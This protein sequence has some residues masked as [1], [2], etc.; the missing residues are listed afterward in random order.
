ME[1]IYGVFKSWSFKNE[2][3]EFVRV[4]IKKLGYF[5]FLTNFDTSFNRSTYWTTQNASFREGSESYILNEDGT[6]YANLASQTI[7]PI[8]SNQLY[9]VVIKL[10]LKENDTIRFRLK[11]GSWQNISG[12]SGAYKDG[13]F[14][15]GYNMG[16][17]VSGFPSFELINTDG[18]GNDS[19]VVVYDATI[20]LPPSINDP[21]A[22]G[23]IPATSR[24]DFTGEGVEITWNGQGA[25]R[26]R[27][28][29]A[30][31]LK[32]HLNITN[33]LDENFI[34]DLLDGTSQK[35]I[36]EVAKDPVQYYVSTIWKGYMQPSF[37]VIENTSFPYRVT[38]TANDSYG[39]FK[40]KQFIEFDSPDQKKINYRLSNIL[41]SYPNAM[42]LGNVNLV[43]N[44][45]FDQ[46]KS[47]WYTSEA[48]TVTLGRLYID[49]ATNPGARSPMSM[50]GS[51]LIP[52]K[53]YN[54]AFNTRT[55]SG[56]L[57]VKDGGGNSTQIASVNTTNNPNN[58]YKNFDF[59]W[60]QKDN[61]GLNGEPNG[62]HF[63]TTDWVGDIGQ[64][65]CSTAEDT[66]FGKYVR[67]MNVNMEWEVPAM[68]AGYATAD[69]FYIC[70]GAFAS[71]T[72]FP[73]EYKEQDAFN[74]ALKI[75]NLLGF[76]WK[77]QLWFTQPNNLER[78]PAAVS[79]Y[80]YDHTSD[81]SSSQN[82]SDYDLTVTI[83]QQ[84]HVLLAG[85]SFTYEPS[86]N[87]VLATYT[88]VSDAFNISGGQDI[89]EK[90]WVS[91]RPINDFY[92]YGGQITADTEYTLKW[93]NTYE[94]EFY[95]SDISKGNGWT[96]A[97]GIF[98]FQSQVVIKAVSGTKTEWLRM[99]PDGELE[100]QSQY[101]NSGFVLTRG[102]GRNVT[103]AIYDKDFNE[104]TVTGAL[105]NSSWRDPKEGD[106]ITL[107][108]EDIATRFYTP[109]P[110]P[111]MYSSSSLKFK[112]KIPAV[113]ETMSLFIKVIPLVRYYEWRAGGGGG[114][115]EIF[116]SSYI[117]RIAKAQSITLE[118]EQTNSLVSNEFRVTEYNETSNNT[119]NIDLGDVKIGVTTSDPQFSIVDENNDPIVADIYPYSGST[120]SKP[121]TQ[122][123]AHQFLDLQKSPLKI[124]QASIFSKDISPLSVVRY[125]INNNGIYENFAFL[126]GTL[127][128]R[129]MTM[130]GEWYRLKND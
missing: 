79:Y 128:L 16:T 83:D 113:D 40:D 72:N 81:I 6:G 36:V 39:R 22:H 31:E 58:D 123:L 96:I 115:R 56:T 70:K 35:Y 102:K 26:E 14:N 90:P 126:G 64:V 78:D 18:Q 73:L 49:G 114:Q 9:K 60:E 2:K 29:L 62:L 12:N 63:Y 68:H 119:E 67:Y 91:P 108:R 43:V 129:S 30:S 34:H 48:D 116:V 86:L 27:N 38:L 5:N 106:I 93:F 19:T 99:N 1:A 95:A 88:G 110:N 69:Q 124:L 20:T 100:W 75:F 4:T 112:T 33:Y 46:D 51:T 87:S 85:S 125:S 55:T 37:D 10:D 54:V 120:I 53:K 11:G 74:E 92:V 25:T 21:E 80:Q 50:D 41:S 3:E 76:Q 15:I 52:G 89:T 13:I 17:V 61:F 65:R 84:N 111:K 103:S 94:E 101:Q 7:N 107:K 77:G 66:V 8:V 121:F 59:T 118:A 109:P 32:L 117:N 104:S 105:E 57:Y 97:P 24:L 127:K 130:D 45:Y 28:F 82:K 44:G 23:N 122:L 47:N 71:N 98:R 42:N